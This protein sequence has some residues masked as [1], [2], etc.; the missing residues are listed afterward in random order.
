MAHIPAQF[1]HI[2]QSAQLSRT[3]PTYPILSYQRHVQK[4]N[5]K[6]VAS[7]RVKSKEEG[8]IIYET[9]ERETVK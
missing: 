2:L 9:G 7:G 4:A 8:D 1:R 3:L 5:R 6:S